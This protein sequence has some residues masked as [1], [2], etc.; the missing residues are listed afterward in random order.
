MPI[1]R[2][3]AMLAATLS[4]G[5]T[6]TGA[7]A[8][9]SPV[10]AAHAADVPGE[11]VLPAS[12]RTIPR[13]TRI[14]NAGDSGFLW[15]QE[16]DD[17]LLW[18]DYSTG[19]AT[20]L[21]QRLPYTVTYD[22]DSGYF[23][24]V[25]SFAPGWY[26]RGS[27][28]VA[29]Y[30]GGDAPHV[31]LLDKTRTVG[32]VAIP[33]GQAYLGTFG[34]TVL[35]RTGGE[36]ET[37]AA[38]LWR[39]GT[40]TAVTGLPADATNITVE[41]G[42]ARSIILKFKVPSEEGSEQGW[43]HW[44]LIGLNDGVAVALPDRLAE[45]QGWEVNGFR[46][47]LHTVLRDRGGRY[48]FDVLDRDDL[49]G[50]YREIET[51]PFAYADEHGIVGS[52]FL[53]VDRVA[54]GDD[55]YRGQPLWA[56]PTDVDNP[57]ETFL[58]DPSGNQIVQTPDGSAL[59]AGAAAYVEEGDLDWG[60]YRITEGAGGH[61][62][63]HRVTDVT[64]MPAQVYG[65]SLGSGILTT[66]ENSNSYHP[67]DYYGNYRST[68]LTTPATG[69][70][71]AVVRSSVDGHVRG[72][73]GYCY[74][75][76]GCVA[77]F[78]DGTG[79]HGRRAGSYYS[80]TML[81]ANGDA[82]WGPRVDTGE[83]SPE[84]AD[85][86]GRYG[87]VNNLPY[88]RQSIVEFKPGA[89]GVVLEKREPVAA[90]VWG[91]TLWSAAPSG[92][93]VVA[94]QLPGNS[95]V[96][97]FRTTDGCVPTDLQAVGRWVYWVCKESWGSVH[98]S[99]VY[100]RTDK[101][102]VAAPAG[103]VLLGDG[104]LV[105]HETGA[106]LK[107][108]DLTGGQAPRTL[109]ADDELGPPFVWARMGWT[110][111]RFSGGVAYADARQRVHIVPTGIPASALTVIDSTVS[112]QVAG[113]AGSW[114]LSKPAA[115]WQLTFRDQAGAV[116]RTLRG[117]SAQGIL[118][119]TWDG[120]DSAGRPVAD[121]TFTW[122]LTAQPADGQG[123]ALTVGGATRTVPAVMKST[124]R[125]WLTGSFVVG[126]KITANP[127]TSTPAATAYSYRWSANGVLISG[128]NSASFVIPPALLGKRLAVMVI[129]TRPGYMPAL[130]M[131]NESPTITKGA[132]SQA[133]AR[134]AMTGT[135]RVGYTVR[136]SVGTWSPKASSY[137]YEWRLNGTVIRGATGA[138]LELTSS[139][140]GKA[141]TV[142]VLARQTG[143]NDGRSTSTAVTV[144]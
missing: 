12:P 48:K 36:D 40:E 116:I 84:L 112:T 142:T 34:R 4:L 107:L 19:A 113:W 82:E 144:R 56:V 8:V 78:A 114:W 110:V 10:T 11:L 121:G 46:L 93:A 92:G 54:P 49:R 85:L 39:D 129:G 130:T 120:K 141:L 64:P 1:T 123:A 16:G 50:D 86:S 122:A 45:G 2:T 100:D 115:A 20:A 52:T 80:H 18:T 138:T 62:E 131:T 70:A 76:Q 105:Q 33:A 136:A 83:G 27:D 68:W 87:V 32:K 51:G 133:T 132:A 89:A 104:Y 30:E 137:G 109:V 37:Q 17:R 135:T 57:D 79:Y 119:A 118:K 55:K 9:A 127:G 106:G 14:L 90:A 125:P 75:A 15:V 97:T 3:S 63:R 103:D 43:G 88:Q 126:G 72:D 139:M 111:D 94:T 117:S 61:A 81:Y 24:E 67:G 31:T 26:G 91:S 5:L 58:M 23:R 29:L 74:Q 60:I 101:R 71:P 35:T 69:T 128:G 140:R 99:G 134:P 124:K 96:E 73:D 53:A 21:D 28:T 22:M 95:V 6:L 98:A 42:D 65:L 44:S 38:H 59:V 47:G 25:P 77:M 66:A 108:L 143:Y 7:P 13:A 102:M 41:D